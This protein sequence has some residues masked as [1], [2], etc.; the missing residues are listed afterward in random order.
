[1][2]TY[3]G[4]HHRLGYV[5][6]NPEQQIIDLE[7]NIVFGDLYFDAV[8]PGRGSTADAAVE[9]A[10]RS[11]GSYVLK[12]QREGGGNNFYGNELKVHWMTD[13]PHHSVPL[14]HI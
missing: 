9:D 1:M 13:Q 5:E 3:L 12:P 8:G 10:L 4:R 7:S 2:I 6:F 14:D 11:P